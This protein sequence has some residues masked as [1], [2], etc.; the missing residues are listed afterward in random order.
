MGRVGLVQ[1]NEQCSTLTLTMKR[2]LIH[3][4]DNEGNHRRWRGE[5]ERRKRGGHAVALWRCCWWLLTGELL[6]WWSVLLLLCVFSLCSSPLF[7]YVS[8]CSSFSLL[9]V[10]TLSLFP[11]NN[12][13]ALS[14]TVFL[15]PSLYTILPEQFFSPLSLKSPPVFVGGQGRESPYLVQMQGVVSA[16][17]GDRGMG[18]LSFL[19]LWH[20]H[21]S[22]CFVRF[23]QAG[24]RER[25]GKNI[26]NP[27]SSL[28]L[29]SYGKRRYTMPFKTIL[30]NVFFLTVHEMNLRNKKKKSYGNFLFKKNIWKV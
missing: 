10:F 22:M 26:Q 23:V 19:L 2:K 14:Q 25:G 11:T 6:L 29:R 1:P 15:F 21:M 27:S 7:S 17:H 3:S 30:C 4:V 18:C 9:F 24:K 8:F 12:S 16:G 5:G 13:P 20:G 28:S